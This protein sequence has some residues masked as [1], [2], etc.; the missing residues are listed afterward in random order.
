MSTAAVGLVVAARA[1]GAREA[2]GRGEVGRAEVVREAVSAE[3]TAV[4]SE[5]RLRQNWSTRRGR[6]TQCRGSVRGRLSRCTS[7]G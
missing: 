5:E 7:L 6:M 2:V 3:M 4:A 1:G